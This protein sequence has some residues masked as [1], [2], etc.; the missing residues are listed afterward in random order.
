MSPASTFILLLIHQSASQCIFK[1]FNKVEVQLDSYDYSNVKV[2]DGCISNETIPDKTRHLKCSH[3][4]MDV[5]RYGAVQNLPQLSLLW[6]S[7]N[8]LSHIETEAFVNLPS[9]YKLEIDHNSIFFITRGVFTN[10]SVELLYLEH[11]AINKMSTGAFRNLPKMRLISL[12]HND[13]A[14]WDPNW[15]Q[16]SNN[17]LQIHLLGN[18]ISNLTAGSFAP[19]PMLDELDLAGNRLCHLDAL[20]LPKRGRLRYLDLNGNYLRSLHR[21]VFE[22][23][24][25]ADSLSR[26]HVDLR[27]NML[28]YIHV[29]ILGTLVHIRSLNLSKNPWWCG[30]H[31]LLVKWFEEHGKKRM[32]YRGRPVCVQPEHETEDCKHETDEK[33]LEIYFSAVKYPPCWNC[34]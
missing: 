8:N 24:F 11:N 22:N 1:S 19:F 34:C 23:V 32:E 15:F 16:D 13:L 25:S 28:Q 29:K 17:L 14:E 27:G 21:D 26:T 4:G 10:L 20:S 18:K 7:S 9:L 33:A 12:A 2:I 30:C 5:L 31:K 3:F 6:F